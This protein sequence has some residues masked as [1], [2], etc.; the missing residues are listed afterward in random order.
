MI[1]RIG[2][3]VAAGLALVAASAVAQEA[4]KTIRAGG[5]NFKAPETWK[6]VPLR[7][8]MRKA[9]LEVEPVKGDG[10]PASL[11]VFVFPGGAGTV[12]ANVTRWQ[13]Q[14][15]GSDGNPPKIESKTLKGKNTDVTLVET[16]G[17][18]KPSPIPGAPPEPER[19][20]AR[21]LGAI[22][23]TDRY[24]YFLK[25]VGPDKTMTS[26]RPAFEDLLKSIE[27]EE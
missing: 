6:T 25:M 21:L 3:T 27:V 15:V 14:F 26:I 16:A 19:E 1:G 5:I 13:R 2:W 24:G 23:T 22:V 9:Q 12:E 8:T 4:T 18:Y 11:V 7:S 10:F 20:N 17:H